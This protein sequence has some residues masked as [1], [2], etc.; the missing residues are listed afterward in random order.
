MTFATTGDNT[1]TCA[2]SDGS[3][4]AKKRSVV[5]ADYAPEKDS[6]EEAQE[7]V[8]DPDMVMHMQMRLNIEVP[9]DTEVAASLPQQEAPQGAH[10]LNLA[11]GSSRPHPQVLTGA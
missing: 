1:E 11:V 6:E 4:P 8:N 9:V 10:K 3:C 7:D 5:Y 2:E